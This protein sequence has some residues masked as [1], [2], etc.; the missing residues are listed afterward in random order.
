MDTHFGQG[1]P[2]DIGPGYGQPAAFLFAHLHGAM[3]AGSAGNLVIMQMLQTLP[4]QKVATF[5]SD[6]LI[7]YRANRPNVLLNEWIAEDVLVP[8]TSINLLRDDMGRSFLVL[9]G[10]EPD[11]NW[12]K[13]SNSILKI[14]KAH[15]VKLC[16]G[17]HGIPALTTH[18]MAP[19]LRHVSTNPKLLRPDRP[20]MEPSRVPSSFVTFLQQRLTGIQ[21]SSMTVFAPVPYYAAELAFPSAASAL[22]QDVM[23]ATGLLVPIGN[24]EQA[25]QRERKQLDDLAKSYP[26]I[27]QAIQEIESRERKAAAQNL[28]DT[29]DLVE[30]AE[31]TKAF[32]VAFEEEF[33]ENSFLDKIIQELSEVGDLATEADE[34]EAVLERPEF[35]QNPESEKTEQVETELHLEREINEVS[36]DQEPGN[37]Q[38]GELENSSSETARPAPEQVFSKVES[39]K[40]KKKNSYLLGDAIEEFLKVQ[41][42]IPGP[43]IIED[44]FLGPYKSVAQEVSTHWGAND[45][46]VEGTSYWNP[47]AS[48]ADSNWLFSSPLQNTFDASL[49]KDSPAPTL[50]EFLEAIDA[51]EDSTESNTPD[52]SED[53]P[54]DPE[55]KQDN[56]EDGS[57]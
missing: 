37:E 27:A 38:S 34:S 26:P 47:G 3:D 33:S 36:S 45:L 23:R 50:A 42:T 5:S 25:A 12:E 51:V 40:S 14:A 22:L 19:R 7:D 43:S 41:N 18:Q 30:D 6:D 2:F 55:N 53:K 52:G 8:E 24:L 57:D 4:S 32:P 21:V 17:M 46:S 20:T 28:L 11:Q 35:T 9:H 10:H 15:G 13:F 44:D 31:D 48:E 49:A 29:N 16:I 56:S 39:R 54:G 1:L